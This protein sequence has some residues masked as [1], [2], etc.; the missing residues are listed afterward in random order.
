VGTRGLRGPRGPRRVS[1]LLDRQ[2]IPGLIRCLGNKDY[3]L[4]AAAAEALQAI[5]Q[6]AVEPLL[7]ALPSLGD[8]AERT[9]AMIGDASVR[10]VVE[11][12]RAGETRLANTLGLLAGFN[13]SGAFSELCRVAL[14]DRHR[15]TRDLERMYLDNILGGGEGVLFGEDLGDLEWVMKQPLLEEVTPESLA[16]LTAG[17]WAN[18]LMREIRCALSAGIYADLDFL[19][20]DNWP[21]VQRWFGT[22]SVVKGFCE[23]L[24]V[25]LGSQFFSAMPASETMIG[26]A[27]Q[28]WALCAELER[29]L[30]ELQTS[31]TQRILNPHWRV[32]ASE[33][34]V[35]LLRAKK[36]KRG[37]EVDLPG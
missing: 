17:L 7:A 23:G 37:A 5:G 21:D 8:P 10:P 25:V 26:S 20:E 12:M 27:L 22:V 16:S 18:A 14:R 34:M 9:L 2:D 19:P 32:C 1:R 15:A 30:S 4:Q 3:E 35:Q 13:A 11:R 28:R 33:F 6:P 36:R 31:P 29:E 24:D